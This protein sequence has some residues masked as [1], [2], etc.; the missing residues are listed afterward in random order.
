MAPVTARQGA[1][2]SSHTRTVEIDARA[3]DLRVRTSTR[4]RNMLLSVNPTDGGIDLVLPRGTPLDEGL[5]F[6]ESRTRWLAGRLRGLPDRVP[7][8]DGTEIP[9]LGTSLGICHR[10]E[11]RGG[12]WVEDDQI[13]VTGNGEYL[14]R[15]V[16]DLLRRSVRDEMSRRATAKAAIVDRKVTRVSVRDTRTRWGSCAGDGRLSFSWRL[17]LA[18][19]HVLD[20]VVAHE[21]AHLVEM[22]H[23]AKFWRVVDE[24]A[25]DVKQ[26]KAWLT[27]YGQTLH[28]YG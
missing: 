21:V 20:Y 12:A 10:P 4:A 14:S 17:G 27:A 13:I 28:R 11:L 19:L 24:L 3:V 5:G 16:T 8:C 18:P 22:N 15:R 2:A 1:R 26:S 25:D 7:F 23:S 9:V 6:V